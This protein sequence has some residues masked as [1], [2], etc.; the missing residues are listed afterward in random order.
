L[1]LWFVGLS[2]VGLLATLV[3]CGPP[4][5]SSIPGPILVPAND[6]FIGAHPLLVELAAIGGTVYVRDGGIAICFGPHMLPPS[7]EA[8]KIVVIEGRDRCG[9]SLDDRDISLLC[10]VPGLTY[11]DLCAVEVSQA[12][13][14]RLRKCHPICRIRISTS[15]GWSAWPQ[16][17]VVQL[18]AGVPALAERRL[19][20]YAEK[21]PWSR[22]VEAK[23]VKT[24]T[25]VNGSVPG[26]RQI[27]APQA[28]AGRNCQRS[29]R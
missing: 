20:G 21:R 6:E 22:P 26:Y 8:E 24:L 23:G 13:A 15:L 2:A 27:T 9:R 3:S 4:E 16:E 5:H 18:A 10:Q 19:G 1:L 28:H 25:V 29:P 11:L 17:P 7:R 14:D 12:N